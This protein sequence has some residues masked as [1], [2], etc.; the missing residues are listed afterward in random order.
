MLC[1]NFNKNVWFLVVFMWH[2]RYQRPVPMAIRYNFR[3]AFDEFY[4][5]I[6]QIFEE[7]QF[8]YLKI[9]FLDF[10]KYS[11]LLCFLK[12]SV[13]GAKKYFFHIF[14]HKTSIIPYN[15]EYFSAP[16]MQICR[17][18]TFYLDNKCVHQNKQNQLDCDKN[19]CAKEHEIV[20]LPWIK[21]IRFFSSK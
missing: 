10:L 15:F 4:V 18:H 14:S 11:F 16:E 5:I 19:W 1:F 21:R 9:M 7:K 17:I 6:L 12:S 20:I 2:F 8:I 3:D 13:F